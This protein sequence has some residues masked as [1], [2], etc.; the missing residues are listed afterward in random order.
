MLPDDFAPKLAIILGSGCGAVA[1]AI[2]NVVA[3]PYADIPGFPVST[4]AGHAGL[5]VCGTLAG[6]HVACLKG[7][8]HLYEGHDAAILR[9]LIYTL[10]LIGCELLFST[11]AVGSLRESSGPGSLV[12][13]TD[14]INLQ[15]RN[16]L[17]GANDPIGV[18]FPS[19]NDAYDPDLRRLLKETASEQHI[20]LHEGVYVA[21]LGPSFETPAEIRAFRTLGG[22]VVGMSVV[23]EVILARHCGLR[24]VSMSIVVNY[25]AG[26]RD[27]H[28]THEETLHYTALAADNVAKL[29]K[30]FIGKRE[31]WG[32]AAAGAGADATAA[33]AA[34][35]S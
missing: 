31:H 22:D 21:C 9:V 15:M 24:V 19:M 26:M 3:I 30:G 34:A 20:E 4:V 28:I 1:D 33:A 35:S 18:R 29:M 16:P 10:R 17:I 7:R 6:V 14:H 23:P 13:L 5:L 27:G 2:E 11:S 32:L 25:A 12:A 8:V